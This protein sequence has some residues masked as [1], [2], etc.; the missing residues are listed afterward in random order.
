MEDRISEALA[1]AATS[2]DP[3]VRNMAL[4]RM[5]MDQEIKNIDTFLNLYIDLSKTSTPAA[6]PTAATKPTAAAKPQAKSKA[7]G[8]ASR[9]GPSKFIPREDFLAAIRTIM[10]LQASPIRLSV[11]H[12]LFLTQ[13]PDLTNS[14]STLSFKRRLNNQDVVVQGA[15]GLWRLNNPNTQPPNGVDHENAQATA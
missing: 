14:D 9:H 1:M 8:N 15:D 5:E 7:N 10:L 4:R 13:Y 12:N 3:A 6:K 2:L 11:M